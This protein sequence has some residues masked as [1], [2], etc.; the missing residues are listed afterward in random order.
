MHRGT[1]LGSTRNRLGRPEPEPTTSIAPQEPKRPRG[2][3][4]L[5]RRE[6]SLAKFDQGRSA[7][8]RGAP[9]PNQRTPSDTTSM[10]TKAAFGGTVPSDTVTDAE[11][12]EARS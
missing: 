6:A 7:T 2:A 4:R 1:S 9:A 10:R 11:S 5:P 3:R 8:G 12:P